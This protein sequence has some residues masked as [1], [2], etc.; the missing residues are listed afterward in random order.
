MKT[1][2]KFLTDLIAR[3]FYGKITI[4]FQDG[5]IIY[6]NKEETIKFDGGR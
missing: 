6:L 4:N 1:L 3:K 5:K 2:I